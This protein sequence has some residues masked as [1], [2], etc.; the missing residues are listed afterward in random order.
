MTDSG[1]AIF[2]AVNRYGTAFGT[3]TL[4]RISVSLAAYDRISSSWVLL[5]WVSPFATFTSTTK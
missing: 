1:A 5:T 4:R 3:L 2:R